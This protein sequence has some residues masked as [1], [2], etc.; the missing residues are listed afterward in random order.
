MCVFRRSAIVIDSTDLVDESRAVCGSC[1][2]CHAATT[3]PPTFSESQIAKPLRL[4]AW[5]AD[6]L[7]APCV[8]ACRR[9]CRHVVDRTDRGTTSLR[10]VVAAPRRDWPQALQ[11]TA[12]QSAPGSNRQVISAAS[13]VFINSVYR[14]AWLTATAA[15]N[16]H[17]QPRRTL[18]SA[19]RA[20]IRRS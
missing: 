1:L 10:S 6:A 14:S 3:G 12:N 4:G 7:C 15:A 16:P 5:V 20:N 11:P 19:Q 2:F 13:F 9:R 17:G 18:R 8:A